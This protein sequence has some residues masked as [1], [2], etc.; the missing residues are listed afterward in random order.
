MGSAYNVNN[1]F[2]LASSIETATQYL[3]DRVNIHKLF[4]Q[5]YRTY[6]TNNTMKNY[7]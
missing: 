1:V 5:Q 7:L 3:Y 6:N 2:V 4:S